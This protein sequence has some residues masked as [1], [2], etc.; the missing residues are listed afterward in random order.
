MAQN[1]RVSARAGV[2][3]RSHI[4]MATISSRICAPHQHPFIPGLRRW[5]ISSL[6]RLSRRV[7]RR[8]WHAPMT[9]RHPLDRR[10]AG[11]GH[12]HLTEWQASIDVPIYF[13]D[14]G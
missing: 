3:A 4:S 9:L 10:A 5:V 11:Q 14:D 6:A 2:A 7:R 12:V 1:A 8:A 13:G